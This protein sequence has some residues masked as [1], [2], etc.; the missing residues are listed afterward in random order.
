[1]IILLIILL[2]IKLKDITNNSL[3]IIKNKKLKILILKQEL[4]KTDKIKNVF[5]IIDIIIN[6][7][8]SFYIINLYDNQKI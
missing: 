4:P 6:G 2:Y 8:S 3:Y 7:Y 1:M 5:I